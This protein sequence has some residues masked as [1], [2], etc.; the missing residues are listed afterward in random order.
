MGNKEILVATGN[1]GKMREIR[2]ICRDIPVTLKSLKDIWDIVPDIP[3]TGSTLRENALIKADWVFSRKG[4][5]VLADDSGLEVEA[6]C[7]EP[8]V[9][10][11]RYAG[12]SC[13]DEKNIQK[14]L[15][16]LE[17]VSESKRRACFKCVIALQISCVKE[18][19]IVVEG[20]CQ[21][22]ISFRPRGKQGFGYDPVFIPNGYSKTFAEFSQS[23]K[24][25]ISHRGKA[26]QTIKAELDEL[27]R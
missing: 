26:L 15:K 3:E 20:V 13:E 21:G 22:T 17:E 8:G 1:L 16:N 7:G 24:N 18:E 10:S 9:L 6:L 12:S 5:W 4:G 19:T 25:R 27:F 14:L 11:S 2:A 23:E